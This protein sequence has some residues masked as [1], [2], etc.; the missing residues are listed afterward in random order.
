MATDRRLTFIRKWVRRAEG[1]KDP[2]DAF[3][4]VW[5]ALIVAAQRLRTQLGTPFRQAEDDDRQRVLD[6]FRV[7][8]ERIL[9]GL[10]EHEAGMIKL[11][12]RR[13]TQHGSPIVDTGNTDLRRRFARLAAHYTQGPRLSDDELVRNVAE[14]FNKIRNNVFHGV[15]V[16]DDRDDI[17]VLEQVNPVLVAVLRRCESL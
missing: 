12:H 17:A 9:A 5:I 7:N 6:Y 11:A 15:K 16:Y 3:F 14:L 13:G 2:F 1:A 10:R 4:S 8:Q